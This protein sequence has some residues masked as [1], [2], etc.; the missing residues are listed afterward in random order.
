MDH[1]LSVIRFRN[2]RDRQVS[3]V[4]LHDLVSRG[5]S[6]DWWERI[7]LKGMSKSRVTEKSEE[8]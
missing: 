3:Q 1:R 7:V 5:D 4:R 6:G 8:G 2:G